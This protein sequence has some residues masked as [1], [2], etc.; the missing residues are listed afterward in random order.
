MKWTELRRLGFVHDL[1]TR[2]VEPEPRERGVFNHC[3][4]DDT[5]NETATICFIASQLHISRAARKIGLALRV[6]VR[7]SAQLRS[8]PDS[9]VEESRLQPRRASGGH[10]LTSPP[11]VVALIPAAAR[12]SSLSPGPLIPDPA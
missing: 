6:T 4:K 8:K 10:D 2:F 1:R 12:C 9:L 5:T 11:P 3:M 7:L